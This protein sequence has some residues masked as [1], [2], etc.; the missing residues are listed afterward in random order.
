MGNLFKIQISWHLLLKFFIRSEVRSPDLFLKGF[1]RWTRCSVRFGAPCDHTLCT[2]E[3]LPLEWFGYEK[4]FPVSQAEDQGWQ[5]GWGW[6]Q[7]G[8]P[9]RGRRDWNNSMEHLSRGT[10]LLQWYVRKHPHLPI[11]GTG[12]EAR[13]Q[14][15]AWFP[16]YTLHVYFRCGQWSGYTLC[17][18][19]P[20]HLYIYLSVL[21]LCNSINL[22]L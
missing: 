9:S 2:R 4:K 3:V 5:L 20:D 17:L 10:A 12:W 15:E 13:L 16:F 11:W 7:S 19:M 21:P 22:L 18:F 8:Q 1:T 6:W 14:A